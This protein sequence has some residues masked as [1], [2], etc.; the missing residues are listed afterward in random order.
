MKIESGRLKSGI[1]V[2]VCP[3]ESVE[4][5]TVGFWVGVG[6]RYE[7][8]SQMG[9]SHFIEHLLFK[10]TR[11][12]NALKITES[13]EGVGGYLNAF[14]GEEATCYYASATA[15]HVELVVDVLSDMVLN[16]VFPEEEV[17]RERGVICEEIRMYEDQPA[18]VSQ[19]VLNEVL[20]GKH[21]LG[22]RITGTEK[23]VRALSR[24]DLM[25]YWKSHYHSGNLA[26]VVAGKTSLQ[27]MKPLLE[28]KLKGVARGDRSIF[29]KWEKGSESTRFC[30]VK[31]PI[32]QT[33]LALGF[34]GISRHDPRRF[35]F[36]I[37]STI[38]GENMS[39]RLFQEIREKN[40]LAYSIQTMTSHF[41]DAGLFLIQSGVD[42]TKTTKSLQLTLRVL[43][44]ITQKAPS[45]KEV[46]RAKE[47]VMGQFLLGL[48]SSTNQMIWSGESLM[49]FGGVK[50]PSE[51]IREIE[52]ITPSHVF[53][54]AK[55]ILRKDQLRVVAVSPSV[56]EKELKKLLI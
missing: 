33:H 52:K 46:D 3:M 10:G 44:G 43:D 24:V 6:G 22:Y 9:A 41:E 53:Q 37:L 55:E 14:T 21:P 26:V 30:W 38:L 50:A 11:R 51:I 27:K 54:L 36:K 45:S 16:S 35:S 5:V 2:V 28:K 15:R 7:T 4:S 39:S 48:E 49:G 32:E 56:A 42:L 40:G 29:K 18:Q 31:K 34:P 20:W 12:R 17:E 8:I 13:I 25:S 1:P 19:E 23:T 47:Y